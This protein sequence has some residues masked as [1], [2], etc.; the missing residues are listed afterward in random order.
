V[1]ASRVDV[2]ECGLGQRETGAIRHLEGRP[3]VGHN[4]AERM[5]ALRY[6]SRP[7]RRD[8]RTAEAR[9]SS[10]PSGGKYRFVPTSPLLGFL[11][12]SILDVYPEVLADPASTAAWYF[13]PIAVT[14]PRRW[15]RQSVRDTASTTLI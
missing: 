8:R 7:G 11:C 13:E 10:P 9:G 5:P 3:G 12:A 15:N 1:E 6:G 4:S 2:D 14:T